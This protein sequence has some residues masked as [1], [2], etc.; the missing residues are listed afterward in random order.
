MSSAVTQPPR[1]AQRERSPPSRASTPE[2]AAWL[3]A[4]PC[5]LLMLAAIVLLGPPLAEVLLP[6]PG[7]T[8]FPEL[9][10]VPEPT[11]QAR[12][13]IA[14]LG[15]VVLS[16]AVLL[17]SRRPMRLTPR[18]EAVSRA[19]QWLPLA[20]LALAIAGQYLEYDVW[21]HSRRYFTPATLVVA[22]GVAGLLTA[23]L[24]R[25]ERIERIA[26]ALRETP[27][28][29]RLVLA[30]AVLYALVWL[31]TS[32]NTEGSI[33]RT[34]L[35]V[36]DNF[37]YWIDEVFAP[38]DGAFPLADFHAQYG[39]LFPTAVAGVMAL[40]G[41]S[42]GV[43]AATMTAC[44]FAALIAMYATLRRL[45]GSSLVALGLFMPFVAV[46]FFK[47]QGTLDDRYG[48]SNL[49]SLFPIRYGGPF[50]LAWLLIRHLDG[51]RPFSRRPL[52]FLAGLI[53]VNT[54]EFGMPCLGATLAAFAW[55]LRPPS[56]RAIARLAGDAALGVGAAV[57]T[58][59]LLT[60][61]LAGEFPRFAQASEF[62]VIYGRGGF[63]MLP[64][65]T[66]GFHL[67]IY[68]TFVAAVGVA[69]VRAIK[70]AADRRM[71]AMLCWIGI[72]GLGASGYFAGR[73]HAEV[74][75]NTFSPWAFAIAL[76]LL[77]TVRAIARR[78]VPRPTPAEVAVMICFG[79]MVCSL[80]QTPTPWSQISRL[81]NPTAEPI[82]KP[83]AEAAY[84]DARTYDGEEVA[85]LAP[86][87][88]RIAYEL[89]L[90][91]AFPYANLGSVPAIQQ[92]ET[93]VEVLHEREIQKVYF[94]TR[95]VAEEQL[96]YLLEHG[97][98]IS[99]VNYAAKILELRRVSGA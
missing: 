75:I 26:R 96:D 49:F 14:L 36:S 79:L 82:M 5:A 68:V 12:F 25:H 8:F 61:A 88:H 28:R 81:T 94:P 17:A 34:H 6:P 15:P 42:F 51:Q 9:M 77:L 48:P 4:I 59:V 87:G 39:Q 78:P 99:D 53:V 56:L 67:A 10:F 30:A 41:T 55:T 1:W 13:M 57:A 11:E 54:P 52:F 22:V 24:W 27:R 97:Y 16:A 58:V 64:M 33:G 2:E 32:F 18:A 91:N 3:V 40:A 93:I 69:T 46:G 23:A 90:D 85:I 20:V 70:G 45:A 60:L 86:L 50:I 43:Y 31:L 44:I 83:V 7:I 29:R 62:T 66:L 72:F 73:S 98:E 76:L 95:R 63:A 21:I 80:A 38:L 37:P 65:P 71:T 89:G 92:W 35:A 84:I 19:V 74:L 47:E